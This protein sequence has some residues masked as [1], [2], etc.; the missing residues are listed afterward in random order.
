MHGL[1]RD[2]VRVLANMCYNDRQSQDAVREAGGIPLILAST[3][4]D[5]V[6]GSQLLGASCGV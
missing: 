5:E 3:N 4:I 2:L 6:R 1:K